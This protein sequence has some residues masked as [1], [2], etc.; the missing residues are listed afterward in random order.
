MEM[1]EQCVRSMSLPSLLEVRRSVIAFLHTGNTQ[2]HTRTGLFA[3]HPVRAVE[4]QPA[5]DWHR[6]SLKLCSF[7][8][9]RQKRGA[10]QKPATATVYPRKKEKKKKLQDI[11]LFSLQHAYPSNPHLRAFTLPGSEMQSIRRL[12]LAPFT[13]C[14]SYLDSV[15][16]FFD[17]LHLHT[18]FR[19]ISN[20]TEK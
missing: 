10:I 3:A 14:V 8:T 2:T 13:P 18:A 15:W 7:F 6:L 19:C 9:L 11:F 1:L 5:V 12:S 16:I 20:V 17:R 4:R